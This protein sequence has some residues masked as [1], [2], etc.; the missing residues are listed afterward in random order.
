[1]T[2]S[3]TDSLSSKIERENE[4]DLAN[5]IKASL[6]VVQEI[7]KMSNCIIF[8][9]NDFDKLEVCGSMGYKGNED[10]DTIQNNIISKY[11]IDQ[12]LDLSECKI[13]IV[14]E[15]KI[16]DGDIYGYFIF[17]RNTKYSKEENTNMNALVKLFSQRLNKM[18]VIHHRADN[19]L[20]KD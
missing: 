8:F 16:K 1:M 12:E 15:I 3:L 7:A 2:Y 14:K 13:S 4:L 19:Y 17:F 5:L 9:V 6:Y 10:L 11:N 20:Q 18:A